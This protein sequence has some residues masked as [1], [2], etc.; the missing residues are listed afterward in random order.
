MK[1]RVTVCLRPD[2]TFKMLM[3]EA[4]RDLLVRELQSL[5]REWDHFHL[6]GYDEPELPTDVPLSAVA[7]HEDDQVLRHGKVLLRPDDWDRQYY[8]HVMAEDAAGG[9]G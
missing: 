7:Y 8:P 4:G 2:G 5:N 3:N 6:D 1:P 9:E